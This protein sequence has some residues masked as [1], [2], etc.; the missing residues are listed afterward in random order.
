MWLAFAYVFCTGALAL[1]NILRS[2]RR[3]FYLYTY[4]IL[5]ASTTLAE[6]LTLALR[7]PSTALSRGYAR[8]QLAAQTRYEARRLN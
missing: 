4:G 3:G 1:G 5:M 7:T 8:A 6:G 2:H